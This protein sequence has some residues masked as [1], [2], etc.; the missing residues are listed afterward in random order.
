LA[1]GRK[2]EK[3]IIMS[4]EPFP[5][6][7]LK[8]AAEDAASFASQLL[9][10]PYMGDSRSLFKKVKVLEE[11]VLNLEPGYIPDHIANEIRN[12]YGTLKIAMNTEAFHKNGFLK[13]QVGAV[14]SAAYDLVN[15]LDNKRQKAEN[16]NHTHPTDALVAVSILLGSAALLGLTLAAGWPSMVGAPDYTGMV[17]LEAQKFPMFTFGFVAGAAVCMAAYSLMAARK[18][19]A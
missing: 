3:V 2:D 6:Y 9:K 16:K 15:E 4:T 18:R 1:I 13:N 8:K 17:S 5:H 7:N 12:A 11:Y 19:N 14:K 10:N